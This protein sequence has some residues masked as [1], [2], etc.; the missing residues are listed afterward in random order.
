MATK[1]LPIKGLVVRSHDSQATTGRRTVRS[2]VASRVMDGT[3][4]IADE[5][6]RAEVRAALEETIEAE[7]SRSARSMSD[8]AKERRDIREQ[9]RLATEAVFDPL[10]KLKHDT[11]LATEAFA[12]DLR[13]SQIVAAGQSPDRAARKKGQGKRVSDLHDA[14]VRMATMS[15]LMPLRNGVNLTSVMQTMGTMAGMYLL[16]PNLRPQL[17]IQRPKVLK[18][19]KEKI[20]DRSSRDLDAKAMHKLDRAEASGRGRE[21]LSERWQR[22]LEKMESGQPGMREPFTNQTAAMVEVGLAESAYA[23]LRDPSIAPEDLDEHRRQVLESY[24]SGVEALR[25]FIAEDGLDPAEVS[26]ASR[27]LVGQRMEAEP[28]LASVFTELGHGRFVKA[29]PREVYMPGST[30]P[31]KVWTGGYVDGVTDQEVSVGSLSLRLPAGRGDHLDLCATTLEAELGDA[32]DLA[33]LNEMFASYTAASVMRQYP[34]LAGGV[35]DR[36]TQLRMQRAG[37]MFSSMRADGISQADQRFIYAAAFVDAMEAVGERNPELMAQWESQFGPDWQAGVTSVVQSYSDMGTRMENERL[38][39]AL[40]DRGFDEQE[41]AA[42][43]ED[44]RA[45]SEADPEAGPLLGGHDAERSYEPVPEPEVFEVGHLAR[46][47]EVPRAVLLMDR[48]SDW[49]AQDMAHEMERSGWYEAGSSEKASGPTTGQERY[50]EPHVFLDAA[51]NDYTQSAALSVLGRKGVE[52]GHEADTPWTRRR[53]SLA[54]MHEAMEA[55]GIPLS[56]RDAMVASAYVNGLEKV[57]AREPY[58]ALVVEQVVAETAAKWGQAQVEDWRE[59]AYRRT[60]Q[61]SAAYRMGKDPGYEPFASRPGAEQAAQRMAAG[62][63]GYAVWQ[64]QYDRLDEVEVAG[65]AKVGELDTPGSDS[66]R[67]RVASQVGDLG[68]SVG[69]SERQRERAKRR[70]AVRKN[71][72]YNE[73]ERT[74]GP[75]GIGRDD[76]RILQDGDST[77]GREADPAPEPEPEM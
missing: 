62:S 68:S 36:S 31:S 3:D 37:A 50:I 71:R 77:P 21:S 52:A 24:S 8:R 5:G 46:H 40:V 74:P 38:V 72:A 7:R 27:V 65:Q 6:L 58:R 39:Q 32:K 49:M 75:L 57:V 64:R 66:V 45:G 1:K 20:Q 55:E 47:S 12:H 35:E 18:W 48:M 14:H 33:E 73:A 56:T 67:D 28:G 41:A 11:Q 13:R 51:M 19:V 76:V 54:R 16:S 43:V 59:W 60:M 17:G 2:R 9:R 69:Q 4:R 44:F 29:E 53:H 61:D 15:A 25:D 23:A 26:Q 42:E 63:E 30:R 34:D 10:A 22:R 70:K